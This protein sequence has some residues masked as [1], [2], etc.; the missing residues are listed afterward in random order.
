MCEQC[1][2]LMKHMQ[3][4]LDVINKMVMQG[5]RAKTPKYL[6]QARLYIAG[7]TQI[8]MQDHLQTQE[9][10][11]V[12]CLLVT[13]GSAA[14]L[15]IADRTIGFLTGTTAMYLGDQGMLIRPEDQIILTQTNP[16]AMGLELFGEEMADRGLRW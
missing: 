11:R 9:L 13:V 12:T 1:H 7:G 6:T 10:V 2:E 15:V 16:S 5:Q 3:T 8:N 14:T 4:Q